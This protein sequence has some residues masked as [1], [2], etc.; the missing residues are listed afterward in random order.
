VDI[1]IL[2]DNTFGW[3]FVTGIVVC[4]YAIFVYLQGR[5]ERGGKEEGRSE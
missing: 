1:S 2:A 4:G 3:L 5:L